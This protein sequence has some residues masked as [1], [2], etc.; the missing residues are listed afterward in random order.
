MPKGTRITT[1]QTCCRCGK[2]FT[3]TWS[4]GNNPPPQYCSQACARAATWKAEGR[5]RFTHEK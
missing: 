4:P 5:R 1:T 2:V 3:R